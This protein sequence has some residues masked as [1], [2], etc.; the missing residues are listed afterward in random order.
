M[1]ETAGAHLLEGNRQSWPE[2]QHC[3]LEL[4]SARTP[5]PSAF[6]GSRELPWLSKVIWALGRKQIPFP[7]HPWPAALGARA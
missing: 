3:S 1:V 6:R 5:V 2:P 7:F 4:D